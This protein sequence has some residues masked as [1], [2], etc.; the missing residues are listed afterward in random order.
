MSLAED[1]AVSFFDILSI[2]VVFLEFI[3]ESHEV[4]VMSP[5][6]KDYNLINKNIL[7]KLL[8]DVKNFLKET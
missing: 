2:G 3:V 5:D 4:S 8:V 7:C 1:K 6:V